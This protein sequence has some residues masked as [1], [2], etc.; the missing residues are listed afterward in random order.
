MGSCIQAVEHGGRMKS[1]LTIWARKDQV[2]VGKYRLGKV[3]G[4][5]I[6]IGEAR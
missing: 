6:R 4:R 2:T 1:V 3:R 5:A